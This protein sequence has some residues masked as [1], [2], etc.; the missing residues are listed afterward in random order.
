M[1]Q[2]GVHA[3]DMA[4]KAFLVAEQALVE[5]LAHA[6]H[7]HHHGLQGA[8]HLGQGPGL[9]LQRLVGLVALVG[10]REAAQFGRNFCVKQLRSQHPVAPAHGRHQAQHGR[11]GNAGHGRAKRQPQT[12]YRG[13]KCGADRLDV[14]G[15]F[16]RE[17]RTVQGDHHAQKRTQHAQHDQQAHQIR[18]E[19]G[20]GQ[21]RALTLD[22]KPH[23]QAH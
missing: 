11:R 17:H 2:I 4:V 15:S 19:G 12:S 18:C 6:F 8:H 22:A 20:A 23:S 3:F 21:T 13:G 5:L 1:G 7:L 9:K 14:G 16:Q 10:E